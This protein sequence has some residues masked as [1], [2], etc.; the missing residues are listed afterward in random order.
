MPVINRIA[1]FAERGIALCPR[2]YALVADIFRGF[3]MQRF[4]VITQREKEVTRL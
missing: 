4:V 1:E 2:I 3:A